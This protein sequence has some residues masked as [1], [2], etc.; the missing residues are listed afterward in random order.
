LECGETGSLGI[1]APHWPIIPIGVDRC[2]WSIGG[3]MVSRGRLKCSKKTC[4]SANF[5][6]KFYVGHPQIEPKQVTD[7]QTLLREVKLHI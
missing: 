6:H 2:V 1:L 7:H 3:M 4:P 5:S